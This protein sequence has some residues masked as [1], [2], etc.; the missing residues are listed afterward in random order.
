MN[1]LLSNAGKCFVEYTHFTFDVSLRSLC[2]DHSGQVLFNSSDS[3][4]AKKVQ[5]GLVDVA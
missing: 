3:L 5:L 2:F 1:I 4:S